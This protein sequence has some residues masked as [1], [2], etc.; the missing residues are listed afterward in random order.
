M[1]GKGFQ[2]RKSAGE[3]DKV[4]FQFNP[5]SLSG[6][7]CCCDPFQRLAKNKEV[8]PGLSAGH[9]LNPEPHFYNSH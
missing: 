7:A 5:S 2:Q 3:G 8:I 1:Y 6:V 9:C 4:L